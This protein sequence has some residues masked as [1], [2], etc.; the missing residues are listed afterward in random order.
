MF[1]RESRKNIKGEIYTYYKLVEAYR[2]EKGTPTNRTILDFGK[3]DID[4]I[5]K[6][7][8]TILSNR[9]NE[10]VYTKQP[11]LFSIPDHIEITARKLSE[12]IIS[13]MLNKEVENKIEEVTIRPGTVETIE[14]RSIGA[15]N[16]GIETL[17][18]LEID[19]ILE[20]EDFSKEEINAAIIS[21]VGRLVKPE[22]ENA[23]YRWLKETSAIC[24][25][26]DEDS[27]RFNRNRL[28]EITD[29]LYKSKDK[30]EEHLMEKEKSL[31]SLS[32]T[33]VLYDLT[34]TFYEGAGKESNLLKRGHSKEKRGDCK[35]VTLAMAVDEKGFPKYSKVY[36]GNVSEPETLKEILKEISKNNKLKLFSEKN[37]VVMDAG[38]LTA[39]NIQLIKDAGL[40]YLGVARSVLYS[41]EEIEEMNILDEMITI[42]E[43]VTAKIIKRAEENV[44]YCES[45]GKK[46]KENGIKNL[47]QERYEKELNHLKDGLI[48]KSCIKDYEK[49]IEK[50]G[51]LKEKYS[52]V[53]K[54]Y[55]LEIIKE[56]EGTKAIDIKWTITDKIENR[57]DGS[58]FIRTSRLDLNEK[59][60]IGI[61][62][63]LTKVEETF[64]FFKSDLGLRPIY[65]TKDSRIEAHLFVTVLAY[66]LLRTIEHRLNEKG[67][68]HNWKYIR[69]G[70]I[71]QVRVTTGFQTAA[72]KALYVRNTS[73][74]NEFQEKIY[75]SLGLN[76]RPMRSKSVIL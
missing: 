25:L 36:A 76:S 60:I 73:K 64:R 34:N 62:V 63:M 53:S 44:L 67:I 23:T 10:I 42:K 1:I 47:F 18:Y 50:C 6:E 71:Y 11:S 5:E 17:K 7:E 26:L 20:S 31:F 57:Y 45:E 56:E 68:K 22:S 24:E 14:V 72:G 3:N 75:T 16:I 27:Q 12:K 65:H 13:K 46:A 70:M 21:I 48:K 54:Y 66:H 61:Y 43:G 49:V 29:K 30:I 39:G 9:I 37:T 55:E 2:N 59:E 58:Y 8:F 41:R 15:E 35:L 33:I 38:I 51:K 74:A 69:E 19:K 4:G 40:D 32:G 52:R 28:Y